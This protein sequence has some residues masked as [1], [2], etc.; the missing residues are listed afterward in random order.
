MSDA[1]RKKAAEL[2]DK[3]MAQKNADGSLPQKL[4]LNKLK[5]VLICEAV[6]EAKTEINSPI[7]HPINYIVS[8]TE[9]KGVALEAHTEEA[10]KRLN[11]AAREVLG[12]I[13]YNKWNHSGENPISHRL[14]DGPFGTGLTCKAPH[15]IDAFDF[16]KSLRSQGVVCTVFV[17]PESPKHAPVPAKSNEMRTRQH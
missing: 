14:E 16:N 11:L 12:L 1:D 13:P 5:D 2:I 17:P 3:L 6:R 10:I 9:G 4:D 15:P 8:R 7:L